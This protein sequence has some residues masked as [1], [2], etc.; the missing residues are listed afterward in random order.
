MYGC[1]SVC[2][3]GRGGGEGRERESRS[4]VWDDRKWAE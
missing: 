1:V 2:G 3:C 4:F